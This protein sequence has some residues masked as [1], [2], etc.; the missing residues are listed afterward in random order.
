MQPCLNKFGPALF[1]HKIE[2][3][4]EMRAKVFKNQKIKDTLSIHA[5]FVANK[6]TF[7]SHVV[8][9]PL[10]SLLHAYDVSM[11]QKQKEE[12]L[13]YSSIQSLY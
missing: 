12:M 8:L 5:V 4:G 11:K 3:M 13:K 9:F 6:L 2:L 1:F 10:P 7:L